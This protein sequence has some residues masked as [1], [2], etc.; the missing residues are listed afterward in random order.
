MKFLEDSQ[1]FFKAFGYCFYD[2][3]KRLPAN[4]RAFLINVV[5]TILCIWFYIASVTYLMDDENPRHH[6]IFAVVQCV[7]YYQLSAVHLSLTQLKSK[8]YSFFDDFETII[9]QSDSSFQLNDINILV[10]FLP[11]SSFNFRMS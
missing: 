11:I 10:Y 9:N 2:R 8:A 3:E 1:Q 7:A 5:S 6:R 4:R